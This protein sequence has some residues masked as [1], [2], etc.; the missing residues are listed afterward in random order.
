MRFTWHRFMA[1]AVKEFIQMRRDRLTFAM[2]LGIPI[3][4]L[5]LFGY[6]INTDPKHLPSVVVTGES[7]IYARSVVAAMQRSD[8]FDIRDEA[9]SHDEAEQMM[10]RGEVQFIVSF[11]VDFARKVVRGESPE[12]LI[13]ADATDPVATGS[14]IAAAAALPEALRHYLPESGSGGAQKPPI[15]VTVQR[16]YNP[17]S[18]TQYNIVPAL[19]GVILTMT[20]VLIT[21]VAI[22]RERERGT[23]EYLLVTPV[24][25]FEVMLGKI[26]PYI[27]VGYIQVTLILIAAKVL[28]HVPMDG[29]L[30][31]LYT[32][33]LFF[34][35]ANLSMGILFSTI[36]RNQLQAF[37][38]SFFFFLP[39]IMLSG[40]MF[41]FRGMPE[42]AQ[43][44]GEVLPLTHFLRMV[45]GLLLKDNGLIELLPNVWP[46]LLFMA[47]V[48]TIALKRYRQTLD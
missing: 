48:M 10:A 12:V 46:L 9:V 35:A 37:Q 44:I 2:M 8:Y 28:F 47:V 3:M 22:T 14:A 42:W 45:R 25:P 13:Q 32:L 26:V 43:W 19:M 15:R 5:I 27:L 29:S 39:S 7:S 38:M 23:L 31:L 41:P 20:M 30:L 21:A 6:A 24:R 16:R 18:I 33:I 34:I 40:F 17:E 4:Q 36:A 1:M 11:P